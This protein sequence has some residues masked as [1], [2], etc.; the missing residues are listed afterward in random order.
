MKEKGEKMFF[1]QYNL[2]LPMKENPKF[3]YA[4]LNSLSGGF[5]LVPQEDYEKLQALKR[6]EV[7][8]DIE[9]LNYLQSRGYLYQDKEAENQRLQERLP[10]F[11][12]ALNET[13]PQVL[14]V[15]TYTC[16]LACP[17]CYE[18]GIKH[19]K[20]LVTK[21]VVDAFFKHLAQ[22]FPGRKPFITLFG[23]EALKNSVKQK[24]MIDYIV[25]G[26][27]RGGYAITAVTNGYDLQEYLDILQQ[28]EIKEIQVTVD[29]P[30]SIHDLRRPTAGGRGS[31]DRIMEGLT[32]A[33][34]RE[35]PIN[36]RAVV[37]KTN[38]KDLV[39]LAEDFDRRGWLDLPPQRF[40]TAIGRNYEL[41]ECYAMPDHLL[42][43]AEHWA[44]FIELAEKYPI[45][46]KFHKPE[47]KGI[48][49]LVQTG[50]LYLPSYDT[51]P[52]CKTEWVYDLYGD[53]Y[54]CT[55][56]AGQ[57]EYKLG[58]FYPEYT[59]KEQET[60]EWEERSVL[61]IPECKDCD[62]SLICGGG[63]GA[64][65]KDRTGRVQGPDCRPI[66]EIL[67][68]GLKYYGDDLLKM[69]F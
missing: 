21:D 50:E 4:I 60:K 39:T 3:P 5:D 37:D 55:A 18:N 7:I 1:S 38:F 20:D 8:E 6:G 14:F 45:L 31:Y 15:P 29:G 43:Q 22:K 36:L 34:Q 46:K 35:I 16:N 51:C 40:K 24:E 9:F 65:A 52:A 28:A 44:M 66:K 69:G 61:T 59:V 19:K 2:I 47:F 23:G 58:T 49:H 30:K 10:E 54:G 17:Y 41:F 33:I 12:N 67:T 25:K 53:I 27:A 64:I 48:N 42:G 11:N 62:V 32:A 26:A 57:D 56:S 68:L 63:C 13:P